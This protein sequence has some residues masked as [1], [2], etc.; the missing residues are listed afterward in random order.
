MAIT[1]LNTIKNWFK[2]GLKPSQAQFWDTWDSFRHKSEKIPA[3]D[4]AGIDDLL[5]AKAD[6]AVLDDH[7][8][9]E[10]AHAELFAAAKIVPSG[11]FIIF[12]RT[13]NHDVLNPDDLVMGIVENQWIIGIYL[14]GDIT[15]LSNFDI[16]PTIE[17]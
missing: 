10:N 16:Y 1:A 11:E 3:A 4:V 14:G 15:L 13:P 7:L 6:K 5:F 17:F 8:T 2:T 9:N 12:K